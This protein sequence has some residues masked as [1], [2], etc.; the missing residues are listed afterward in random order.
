MA[1]V[2]AKKPPPPALERGVLEELLGYH[3]RRSQVS[4]F[5]DFARAMDGMALTP[6]QFG[7]LALIQANPGLSQS[8]LGQA[9]GRRFVEGADLVV[10]ILSASNRDHDLLTKRAEYAAAGIEEY[11]LAD[12]DTR[13]LTVLVL[14][15]DRYRE[16]G[17]FGVGQA[18]TSPLLS[19]LSLELVEVFGR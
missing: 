11:W 12:P 14:D 2:R 18:A 7:V 10:E 16:H 9:M 1:S 3:L 19:E 5:Q 8:A 17:Q 6:G 4:V 13:T 15:G